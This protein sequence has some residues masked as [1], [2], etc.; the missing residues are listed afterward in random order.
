MGLFFAPC[1]PIAI[2]LVA[3]T[4]EKIMIGIYLIGAVL[5]SLALFI[6]RNKRLNY[7]LVTAFVILQWV[8]TI[9]EYTHQDLLQLV[10]FTPDA[11]AIIFLVTLSIICVAAFL[12]SYIFFAKDVDVP[13]QRSIYYASM[14]M[15]LTA[16][17]AAYLS[18]NIAITWIFVE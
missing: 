6:N 14:V 2:G 17:S 7:L 16:L 11:F 8:L 1:D 4:I 9:Y 12:H 10:Y 5:I 3:K 15:L 18:N 13:R